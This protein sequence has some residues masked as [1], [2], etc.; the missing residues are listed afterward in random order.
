MDIHDDSSKPLVNHAFKNLSLCKPIDFED[1]IKVIKIYSAQ[2]DLE[3]SVHY[4]I[5]LSLENHASFEN[6]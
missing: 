6:R 1:V 2:C 5:I 4:P 3:N